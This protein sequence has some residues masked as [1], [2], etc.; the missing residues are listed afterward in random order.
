LTVEVTP[1]SNFDVVVQ[2]FR[3]TDIVTAIDTGVLPDPLVL[4]DGFV[5]GGRETL[6]YTFS[7]TGVFIIDVVGFDGDAGTFTMTISQ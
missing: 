5:E 3:D 7:Q 6:T 2:L 1:D 4:T